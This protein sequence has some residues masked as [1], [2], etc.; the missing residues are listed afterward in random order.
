MRCV[1]RPTPLC[2]H[3]LERPKQFISYRKPEHTSSARARSGG[4]G[5]L[6]RVLSRSS[7]NALTKS[8]P[9]FFGTCRV[10]E[11]AALA[12]LAGAGTVRAVLCFQNNNSFP[13]RWPQ[14]GFTAGAIGPTLVKASQREPALS[15][16]LGGR[17]LMLFRQMFDSISG[18]YSYLL[19]S[20]PGG[21]ALLS[22]PCLRRWIVTFSYCGN[23]TSGR[24]PPS[25][26]PCH[27]SRAPH[28]RRA[29]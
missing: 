24:Y 22:I 7:S 8:I 3:R 21:E 4:P 10:P 9:L 19:A 20:R 5:T 14:S 25:R 16:A 28:D 15:A 1:C 27:R 6:A 26:R 23:W 29:N 17:T 2:L 18:T 12:A 11:T 13:F